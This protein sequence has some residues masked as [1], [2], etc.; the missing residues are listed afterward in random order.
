MSD[1]MV[2]GKR[3]ADMDFSGLTDEQLTEEI[4]A[5]EL[6]LRAPIRS[7]FDG[8]EARLRQKLERAKAER[9]RRNAPRP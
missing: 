5:M 9:E 4:E 3:S 8:S 7:P 1:G 2:G 6:A